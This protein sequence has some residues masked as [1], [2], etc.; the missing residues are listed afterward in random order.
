MKQNQYLFDQL[1]VHTEKD[2]ISFHVPGHKMGKGFPPKG[3]RFF[4]GILPIDL[5]ELNGLDDLH[6]PDSVIL[7]SEKR[8]ARVFGTKATFFL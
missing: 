7:E 2:T 4:K 3:K 5:T 1:Q 8:A 6:H